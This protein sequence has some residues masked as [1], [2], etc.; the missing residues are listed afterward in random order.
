[1]SKKAIEG[2]NIFSNESFA[3]KWVNL[4]EEIT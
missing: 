3:A 1:M 2:A 4:I